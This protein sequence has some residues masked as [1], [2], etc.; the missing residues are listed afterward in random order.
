MVGMGLASA[1]LGT[2]KLDASDF[3]GRLTLE[4][5]EFPAYS[6]YNTT[7]SEDMTVAKRLA[8][9]LMLGT[10]S[11]LD[12]CTPSC[13][14]SNLSIRGRSLL[15]SLLSG[16]NVPSCTGSVAGLES[17]VKNLSTTGLATCLTSLSS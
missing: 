12:P 11:S 9:C 6:L 16:C 1:R 8:G 2:A 17:A 4:F 3:S 10:V 14:V 5:E 15:V 7:G 13:A